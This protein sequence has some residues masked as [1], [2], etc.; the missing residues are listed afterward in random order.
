MLI[1]NKI[2][3]NLSSSTFLSF[4]VFL[5]NFCQ[6]ESNIILSLEMSI[7]LVIGM[8]FQCLQSAWESFLH[9]C[10]LVWILSTFLISVKLFPW[11]IDGVCFTANLGILAPM[12][13]CWKTL[14]VCQFCPVDCEKLCFR[15]AFKSLQ[16]T[17][18]FLAKYIS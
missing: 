18:H 9:M 6:I 5:S 8:Q 13:N 10:I 3:G 14:P 11:V 7:E 16:K 17:S 4:S 12:G 2:Y 15:E 1:W